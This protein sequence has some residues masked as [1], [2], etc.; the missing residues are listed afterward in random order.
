MKVVDLVVVVE[1][2]VLHL[3]IISFNN[4]RVYSSIRHTYTGLHVAIF[5]LCI[6]KPIGAAYMI[7][8]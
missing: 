7:R 4:N 8:V 6:I 3:I 2:Y 1:N 5:I